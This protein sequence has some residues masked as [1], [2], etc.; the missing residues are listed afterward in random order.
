[1]ET[2]KDPAP[3]CGGSGNGSIDSGC[4]RVESRVRSGCLTEG[5]HPASAKILVLRTD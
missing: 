4:A 2:T 1:M 5:E 3:P